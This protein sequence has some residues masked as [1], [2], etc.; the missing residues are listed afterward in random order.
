LNRFH[1][2]WVAPNIYY[3]GIG[4]VV[5]FRG[6]R[7]AGWSGIYKD[8]DWSMGYHEKPPF[9]DGTMRT[10]YHVREWALWRMLQVHNTTRL[11]LIHVE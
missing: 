9:D 5:N 7:I 2:G 10:S 1:G 8:K 6:L 11:Y 3:L 4:G